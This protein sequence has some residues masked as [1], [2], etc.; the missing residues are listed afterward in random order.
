MPVAPYQGY[1][2]V[3]FDNQVYSP[4]DKF[5]PSWHRTVVIDQE[6][7]KAK[8]GVREFSLMI[9]A[10]GLAGVDTI[11]LVDVQG[12]PVTGPDDVVTNDDG[13]LAEARF[14]YLLAGIRVREAAQKEGTK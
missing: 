10:E 3:E 8:G 1:V 9:N 7:G 6:T 4:G 14:S 11:E 5:F 2:V 13:T 12:R